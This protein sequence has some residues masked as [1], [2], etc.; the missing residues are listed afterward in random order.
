MRAAL[1]RGTLCSPEILE[2]SKERDSKASFPDTLGVFPCVRTERLVAEREV[3][4]YVSDRD[5]D[6]G[7]VGGQKGSRASVNQKE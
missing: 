5:R 2:H 6:T 7:S 4:P 3:A 1:L